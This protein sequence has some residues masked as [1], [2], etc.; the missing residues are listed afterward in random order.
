MTTLD[1]AALAAARE[2]RGVTLEDIASRTRIPLRHLQELERGDVSRWPAGV[3]ARS[4]ARAYA[5]EAGADGDALAAFVAS[6][7]DYEASTEAIGRA[8]SMHVGGPRTERT[9]SAGRV[10]LV[11]VVLVVMAVAA[12]Y[13]WRTWR[14]GPDTRTMTVPVG[15]ATPRSL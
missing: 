5:E 7:T 1:P 11:V 6:A 2:A 15:A 3:Y 9:V 10:A 12:F 8:R 14:P 4:W 13:A